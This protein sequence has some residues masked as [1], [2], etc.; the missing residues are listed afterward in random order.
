MNCSSPGMGPT[1]NGGLYGATSRPAL[2]GEHRN[3][4]VRL[5]HAGHADR[6][7]PAI[8]SG[9]QVVGT[10]RQVGKQDKGPT[11]AHHRAPVAE[12]ASRSSISWK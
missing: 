10:G 3:S 11:G 9:R 12:N 4:C 7:P 2:A 1:E 5:G 8:H 6:W